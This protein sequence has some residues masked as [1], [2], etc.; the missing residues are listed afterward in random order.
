MTN[1]WVVASWDIL[2]LHGC[3][4]RGEPRRFSDVQFDEP[5]C[6]DVR[7]VN[8]VNK[9]RLRRRF[10]AVNLNLN[11]FGDVRSALDAVVPRR[12]SVMY[13]WLYKL[14]MKLMDYKSFFRNLTGMLGRNVECCVEAV[15]PKLS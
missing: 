14:M 8:G 11:S 5:N 13:A 4:S 10:F 3:W 15:F 12:D 6:I 1:H 2:V 9:I 7:S